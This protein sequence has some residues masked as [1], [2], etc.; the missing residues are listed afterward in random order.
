M[1]KSILLLVVFAFFQ[2]ACNK[3]TDSKNSDTTTPKKEDIYH[4]QIDSLMKVSYERGI[5]NG[6]IL[7]VKN[8]K[9]L[10]Q[11][12]FGY[13]DASKTNK[14]NQNSV[15]N[16]GSIA[17]EFNAVAIMMLKEQG[18][19]SL[20]DKLSKFD[21]G[22]PKW[23][24]TVI[25][26]HLLQYTSGLPRIN[27]NTVKN[28]QDIFTDLRTLEKLNFDAGT[29]Y[30]YNNNNVFLQRRI[31]EKVSGMSFNDF[32][33]KN[34]LVPT[35]MN[36]SIIDPN[37][38]NPQFVNSFSND[39][40][41]DEPMDIEFTGWVCPTINDMQKWIVSLHSGELISKESLI[42]L[43]EAYSENSQSA[44]G[45]GFVENNDLVIHRHHGSSSNYEV[46][47]H[48]NKKENL[49]VILMTN[50][51]NSKL[52]DIIQ[53]VENISKGES[54]EI[55]KKSIYLT[56]RQKSYE[57]VEEGIKLYNDLKEND[58]ETYNFSDENELNQ[59]GY[60]LI[61][62]EQ[63]E[64]AIK[65]FQLLISEFPNSSNPYDSMGEAYYLNGN[66]DLA[67]LNYKKSL[68][69]NP[70]NSN[71]EKMIEKIESEK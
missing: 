5:F 58:F 40:V 35:E 50:N 66:T 7:V 49:I 44:L 30:F 33:K 16:I 29:D 32:V 1:Y 39:L 41:N 36:N 51:K 21:L 59:L 22:L 19:L 47:T 14:L 61:E 53:A 3:N 23:A 6:N 17:K 2:T 13:T 71:A 20:D 60:K 10:Y 26:R 42:T 67:L 34:I 8:T 9:I 68:E 25:V 62:K 12:E 45:N 57:N 69:L 11:N 38:Q 55:P 37:S 28:D 65:I 64:D 46:F 48:Y 4:S 15:F 43:S 27:W 63:I 70:T 56:I 24:E 31:V 18:K 54:F 52:Q